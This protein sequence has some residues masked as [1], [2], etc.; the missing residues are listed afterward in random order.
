MI[1]KDFDTGASLHSVGIALTRSEA[2]ELRSS[3]DDILGSEAGRHEH[4]SSAD[5]QTEV[6]VWLEG[7]IQSIVPEQDT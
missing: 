1:L 5:Y 6:T 3:L 7:A 4:V 2:K